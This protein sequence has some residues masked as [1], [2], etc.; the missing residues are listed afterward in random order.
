MREHVGK[1]DEYHYIL[2]ICRGTASMSCSLHSHICSHKHRELWFRYC[3]KY[4][5]HIG[6][7]NDI[8]FCEYFNFSEMYFGYIQIAIG[9][10]LRH[11]EFFRIIKCS[12]RQTVEFF[13]AT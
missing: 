11:K 6:Y 9:L 12:G 3:T 10:T 7:H 1:C 8:F 13:H 2:N 5:Y 4:V